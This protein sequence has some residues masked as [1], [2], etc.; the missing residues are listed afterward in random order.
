MSVDSGA[1]PG[2]QPGFP[3]PIAFIQSSRSGILFHV[4]HFSPGPGFYFDR[5][6]ERMID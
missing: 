2:I 4:K 3:C 1:A 6:A 5:I